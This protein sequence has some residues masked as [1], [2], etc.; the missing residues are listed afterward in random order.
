MKLYIVLM[1]IRQLTASDYI[2]YK[3]LI[4]DFRETYFTEEQ[5]VH[6]INQL[7]PFN[8]IWV[9][10]K[11]GELVATGT[12][13]FEQKL[14]HNMAILSHIEDICVIKELRSHG[15]GKQ[16]VEHLIG[17]SRERGAYKVTL[18]CNETNEP[19]YIKCGLERRGVQ[20][21]QLTPH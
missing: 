5:F 4:N 11:D 15:F 20:M 13:I 7:H 21:S 8:E 2:S 16:I 19:F 6:F 1:Y 9:I 10:E 17:R 3:R 18:D 12:I 14:I